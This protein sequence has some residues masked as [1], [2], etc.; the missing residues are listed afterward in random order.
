MADLTTLEGIRAIYPDD[1]LPAI[2]KLEQLS[3]GNANYVW[4]AHLASPL[5]DGS[6]TLVIKHAEPH[7]KMNPSA[8]LDDL[9][10]QDE[11]AA[12]RLFAKDGPLHDVVLRDD[13]TTRTA[14]RVP[15]VYHYDET[16]K[17]LYM[18]DFGTGRPTLKEF[19][20][21]PDFAAN[22]VEPAR[23]RR[24]GRIIGSFLQTLHD[25]GRK[26]IPHLERVLHGK[27]GTLT[28]QQLINNIY[29]KQ[30]RTCVISKLGIENEHAV[31][32]VEAFA[33]SDEFYARTTFV[34][35]DFWPGNLLVDS[36]SL[37]SACLVDWE[38]ARIGVPTLDVSQFCAELYMAEKFKG[39]VAAREVLKGLVE[40]Y[41]VERLN[42]HAFAIG[43]ATHVAVVGTY[44][45]WEEDETRL[46]EV[47]KTAAVY[48]ERAD[49]AD[50]VRTIFE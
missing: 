29:Y 48:A 15:S 37:E 32:A 23:L 41:G 22:M 27:M 47:V 2:A 30:Y 4:R 46:R 49:D 35:G 16:T 38:M 5:A 26:H 1:R 43:L 44:Y 31:A 7:F 25:T 18:A 12:L 8:Q 9:R 10:M 39:S 6:H 33:E 45:G 14:V 40:A 34:M 50:F 20:I 11:Q 36:E 24:L 13:D 17:T 42:L 3:G 19:L 21:N 28:K